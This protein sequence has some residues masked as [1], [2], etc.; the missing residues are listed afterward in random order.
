MSMIS[1]KFYDI[2]IMYMIS[3]MIL[4]MI[5]YTNY[6]IIKYEKKRMILLNIMISYMIS[7][8][9]Y[10]IIKFLTISYLISVISV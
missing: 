4:Y 3:C 9:L 6:D 5:S 2:I 7:L 1:L 8:N 10:D